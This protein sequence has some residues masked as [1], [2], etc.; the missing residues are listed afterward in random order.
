MESSRVYY[1]ITF[2]SSFIDAYQQYCKEQR[3]ECWPCVADVLVV[4]KKED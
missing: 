2:A 3:Y 4:M 1:Q